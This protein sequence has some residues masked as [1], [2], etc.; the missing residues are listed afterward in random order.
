MIIG[1]KDTAD[2]AYIIAEAGCNHRGSLRAA[3]RFARL[4]KRCGADAIKFQMF[5]P[6]EELFCP[7]EGDGDRWA[8]WNQ[9]IMKPKKWLKVK[10]Y[11]DAL[12]I[13]FLASVFQPTGIEW[14]RRLEPPAWKV[15]SRAA[16]TFPYGSVDGPFI[17][18]IGLF[19]PQ[20]SS[21]NDI[22]LQC[23]VKYPTPLNEAQWRGDDSSGL[24]DH[25]GTIY[26]ALDALVRGVDCIEV[27]LK[28]DE[29]GPDATSSLTPAQLKL[30]CEVR[31]GFA[32]MR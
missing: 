3:M 12:G 18:S 22:Y 26:P 23:V 7:M 30:I 21:L 17:I 19:H 5:T 20:P 1:N 15:A 31:D 11:C 14:L 16:K 32:A 8:W 25:S 27:H 10:E 2:R 28:L 9:S 29:K 4:A 24:S 6:Q 13:H